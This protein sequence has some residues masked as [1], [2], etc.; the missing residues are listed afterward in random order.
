MTGE[1]VKVPVV[2]VGGG[3]VGLTASILLSKLGIRHLLFEKH[4]G[5]A[6]HPKAVGLN[7]RTIEVFRS[8]GIEEEV[9][10]EAAPKSTYER[11][12]WYTSFDGPTELHG[13]QIAIRDAWGGGKYAKEYAAA[14]PCHYTMLAQIRLEPLLRKKA[15]NLAVSA[16]QFGK[17]VTDIQQDE[18][19]VLVTVKDEDGNNFQV[20]AEYLI[21][22]DGGRTVAK[23]LGI[24]ENGPT[25]LIDMVSAHFSADLSPYLPDNSC[26]INWFINPD[27]GG[28]IGS[29]YLY[30]LGPYENNVSKEWVFACAF[31]S[32]DPERFDEKEMKNRLFRSLGIA[33]LEVEIHSIS[34]WYIQ[35]VVAETFKK[36]RCFLVGDA[37][38]RIPPWGALGLN[39]GIQ[40]VYNL[41]WKLG[42]ALNNSKLSPILET[43]DLERHPIAIAV[44]NSSLSNFQNHGGIIDTALGI[45]PTTPKEEGWE[46]LHELWSDTPGGEK[47]RHALKQAIEI[48]DKEFHA[49]GAELGY[50][51]N[52]GSHISDELS[53]SPKSD[54]LIYR[55]T[56]T[57]G[58]HLPH[59]WLDG[60][61][62]RVSTLDLLSLDCFT[63]LV[64]ENKD[65]W[66]TLVD[67]I[68]A[69]Y[70][71]LIKI[72][73][74]GRESIYT[75]QN[76]EWG[77]LREVDSS[78][79]LLVRP[80]SIV[81]WRSE[82]LLET[83]K[84]L[85]RVMELILVE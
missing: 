72:I 59:A 30:H 81:A 28:S 65:E 64:G 84:A 3:P 57:P 37:A 56:T 31:A 45:S 63:L 8:I 21:G 26:L 76:N 58:Y 22:A 78:G 83:S 33:N 50:H 29:G 48:L 75:D 2:I 18:Q 85:Q 11:T 43:Y 5:T 27:F 1:I 19:G 69:P 6:I 79:A 40:D 70:K 34:H 16:I 47:K 25:N 68:D 32:D 46:A 23:V 61:N 20:K 52:L 51:Y 66:Q 7:Q 53:T 82:S 10:Q 49:H 62:G 9:I 39:T 73:S 24:S 67:E 71:D 17:N 13:R 80:D 35:S 15:E 36:G 60:P 42:M 44:A 4:Q 38:H 14:S 74:I 77:K 54:M 41:V 55:P 12:A